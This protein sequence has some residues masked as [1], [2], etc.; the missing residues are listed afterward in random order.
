[1]TDTPLSFAERAILANQYRILE[2]LDP[3]RASDYAQSREIV[4]SGY[5]FLYETIDPAIKTAAVPPEASQEVYSILDMFQALE[6]SVRRMGSGAE[7]L[8]IAFEGFDGEHD[9]HHYGFAY[10]LRRKQGKWSELSHYP[11]RANGTTLPRYRQMLDA[12][13]AIG[14]PQTMTEAQIRQLA[15][16]G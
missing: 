3:Q 15:D 9:E 14:R 12:W 8:S 5:E 13:Q 6:T 4:E 16:R 11:D 7:T 2:K 10:F 1:M